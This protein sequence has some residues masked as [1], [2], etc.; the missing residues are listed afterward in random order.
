MER[1]VLLASDGSENALRAADFA[2][3]LAA[4][5]PD[6]KITVLVVNDVL[7]KMK[8][9]SPLHSPVIFEEF[10]AF[11]KAK[12]EDALKRTLEALEK[13]GLQAEGVIKVGNPAQEIVNFAREGGF[14]QIVIG[15]RGLGSL[16]GIVL[17]SVSLKVVHLADCP[18][19]VVK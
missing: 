7:E 8:Y 13:H 14:K 2:A 1:K 5:L 12:S 19:T 3:G 10:D 4:S 18:V 6:L 9:Y 15:S 17:G 16:K 11:F